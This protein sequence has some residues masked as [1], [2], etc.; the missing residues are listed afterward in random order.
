[1][2]RWSYSKRKCTIAH[3]STMARLKL[4]PEHLHNS[5]F[6]TWKN[7]EVMKTYWVTIHQTI[8]YRFK[9]QDWEM[10]GGDDPTQRGNLQLHII[11][12]WSGWNYHQDTCA[13]VVSSHGKL[14]NEDLWKATIHQTLIGLNHRIERRD[15]EMIL[16]K[17]EMYNCT[18][19]YNGQV[20]IITRTLA[21]Q[22]FSHL[23]KLRS[24][25][26]LLSHHTSN[27]PLQI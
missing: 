26:D 27:D 21:Q 10:R 3:H 7:W 16:L 13:T 2:K 9:S 18:S 20:E 15:E 22:Q 12:Q 14:R 25:E 5:S 19:F 8:P 11:L 6:L 17:E 24:D 23:E 1:M 4:S